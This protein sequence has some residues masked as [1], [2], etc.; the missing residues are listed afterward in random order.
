MLLGVLKSEDSFQ[1][2]V[3]E[4][5]LVVSLCLVLLH[6]LQVDVVGHMG[7]GKFSLLSALLRLVEPQGVEC[8]SFILAQSMS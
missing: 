6:L 1:I 3:L 5:K 8:S 2:P 4:M 7:A